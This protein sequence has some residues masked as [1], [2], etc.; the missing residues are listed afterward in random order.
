MMGAWGTGIY[1]NDDAGDFAGEIPNG[2]LAAVQAALDRAAQAEYLE[3]PDGACALVAADV[4]A[5]MRSGQGYDDAYS[6]M[7]VTWV[8]DNP[9]KPSAE[10][11]G[12]ALAAIARVR[13]DDSE[14]RELW[15]ENADEL[16]AWLAT[17]TDIERRLST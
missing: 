11:V 3:A 12:H 1:D 6:E 16:P 14:L 17:L 15:S 10:L 2:G 5:R 13:A 4:V 8:S 7:I 9:E